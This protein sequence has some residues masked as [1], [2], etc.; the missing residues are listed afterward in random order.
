MSRSTLLAAIAAL[1]LVP[2]AFAQ[3]V[4]TTPTK[5]H[6]ALGDQSWFGEDDPNSEGFITG[7]RGFSHFYEPIGNPIYFESPFNYTGARFIYLH[8]S[9]ADDSQLAGGEL[10]VYALQLRLAINE[11]LGFIATKDGYSDLKADALPNDKGWNDLA[12]GLKYVFYVDRENDT[13]ATAGF[14]YMVDSGDEEVLQGGVGEFSPFISAAMGFDELHLI[15]SASLRVPMDSDDGNT[16]FQWSFHADYEVSPE[17]MPGFA[18]VF[19][20]HGLHYLDDGART[21][22]SVGGLDYTNLGST[23]VAGSTV[24]WAGLGARYKL[25]PNMQLGLDY[26]LPLTNRNADIF[27]DRITFDLHIMY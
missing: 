11:R 23:D 18:P 13:V 14:R 27:G 15:G 25:N 6:F 3:E 16:I 19:E 2:T 9:F 17:S 22:L 5:A 7:L 20:L 12:A 4:A 24:I 26:E 21:P 1:A 8:H 10:S